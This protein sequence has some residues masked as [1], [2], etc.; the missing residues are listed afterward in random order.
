MFFVYYDDDYPE[1]GGVGFEKFETEKLLFEFIA[2]RI[3]EDPTRELTNY[4][5]VKGDAY[6][7]EGIQYA[8]SFKLKMSE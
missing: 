5:V 3:K 7:L 6:I 4:T 2:K 1:N 8:T